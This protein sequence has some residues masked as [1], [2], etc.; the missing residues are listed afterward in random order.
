MRNLKRI[1]AFFLMAVIV[2]TAFPVLAD[3]SW[4]TMIRDEYFLNDVWR[5]R[6]E[7]SDSYVLID[8]QT[9]RGGNASLK[10]SNKTIKGAVNSY[11]TASNKSVVVEKGKTYRFEFD[12]KAENA[13]GVYLIIDGVSKSL[14]PSG[15]TYDWMPIAFTYT[16]QK[17]GN[18]EFRFTVNNRTDAF[19]VDNIKVYDINNPSV[20]LVADGDFE[21]L[22]GVKEISSS[23]AEA[24]TDADEMYSRYGTMQIDG[25]L[26][27]WEGYETFEIT[28]L[29]D[30]TNYVW[31]NVAP[32]MV[33]YV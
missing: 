4:E 7:Y 33:G 30:Y 26:N 2:T 19:W 12:A 32:Q 14:I 13:M 11:I 17:D 28:G 23:K 31:K 21:D 1:T 29:Q 22:D 16:S 27:D 9:A 3:T 20:N 5:Y 25:K 10:I 6:A 18:I 8:T 15:K 24:T